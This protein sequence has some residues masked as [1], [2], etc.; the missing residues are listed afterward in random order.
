MREEVGRAREGRRGREGEGGRAT[1]GGRVREREVERGRARGRAG[2]EGEGRG[3]GEGEGEGEGVW[4]KI[5]APV[6]EGAVWRAQWRRVCW[7]VHMEDAPG[8]PSS[9]KKPY[10]MYCIIT[11]LHVFADL[12][13][14]WQEAA[15][16]VSFMSVCNVSSVELS[17]TCQHAGTYAARKYSSQLLSQQP[18]GPG[19]EGKTTNV[20]VRKK[21]YLV[22]TYQMQ[23]LLVVHARRDEH[24]KSIRSAV[25]TICWTDLFAHTHILHWVAEFIDLVLLLQ[26][27]IL[28]LHI[29]SGGWGWFALPSGQLALANYVPEGGAW[30]G[31]RWK[32]RWRGRGE[33]A[34]VERAAV[35]AAVERARGR[36]GK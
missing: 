4:S 15:S 5:G 24:R 12:A 2:R 13:A 3:E 1:E 8:A 19:K 17:S 26:T 16:R 23:G 32:V 28:V 11:L 9:V 18:R 25:D 31:W 7:S 21:R 35:G 20:S 22:D 29:T 14:L 6:A 36:W 30:R 34:A 27:R 10:P 33:R